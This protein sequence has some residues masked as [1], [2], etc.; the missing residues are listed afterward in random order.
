MQMSYHWIHT[1]P[2]VGGLCTFQ[3]FFITFGDVGASFSVL[4]ISFLALYTG[5]TDEIGS[6]NIIIE[7]IYS[8]L[9]F[10]LQDKASSMYW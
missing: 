4:L 9:L 5:T 1:G 8:T 10:K 3:S 7:L 6:S 2:Y